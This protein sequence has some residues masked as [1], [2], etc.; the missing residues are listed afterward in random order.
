MHAEYIR[1]AYASA[2]TSKGETAALRRALKLFMLTADFHATNVNTLFKNARPLR[3]PMASHDRKFKAVVVVFLNGGAD[4]FNLLVP[5]SQCK[6]SVDLNAEYVK[7]R[8]P[9]AISKN[10]LLPIKVGKTPQV[11]KRFGV[12]PN[13]NPNHNYNHNHDHNCDHDHD[14][15]PKPNTNTNTNPNPEPLTLILTLT[16]SLTLAS[17]IQRPSD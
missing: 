16:L 12:H 4:T 5:H 9:A 13:P 6:G 2:L 17:G 8:G 14:P 10:R 1:K 3:P 11:C 7:V 15:N